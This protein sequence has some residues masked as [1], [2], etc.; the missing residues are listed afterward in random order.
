MPF[1]GKFGRSAI[2]GASKLP[3]TPFSENFNAELGAQVGRI[4]SEWAIIRSLDHEFK[5]KGR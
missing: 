5:A 2:Q 1:F 3:R 4:I